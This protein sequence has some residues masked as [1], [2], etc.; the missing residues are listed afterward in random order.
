MQLL[1]MKPFVG[2]FRTTTTILAFLAFSGFSVSLLPPTVVART[3]RSSHL[4]DENRLEVVVT[5]PHLEIPDSPGRLLVAFATGNG[6]PRFTDASFPGQ[7]MF[8]LAVEKLVRDKP[9]VLDDSVTGFP[10]GM[11][12]GKLPP[13]QYKVQAIFTHN[14][15]INL[16]NAPGNLR[17]EVIDVN[18]PLASGETLS[19]PL[20][21][22]IATRPARERAGYELVEIPS[23]LLTA[24]HGRP[25]TLR[26][27][28]ALPLES[29]TVE[30]K[31][32]PTNDTEIPKGLIIHIGGFGQRSTSALGLER[33]PRFVQI[34]LDGA[35]P[36]GDPYYVDSENNGPY[37][38]ALIEEIIPY[39]EKTYVC[40]GSGKYRFT[41]GGSTG[42][43][44]SLALQILYPDSFNGCW[45]SCPDGV[46]FRNFQ[47]INI[48][49]DDNAYFA[50]DG[51]EV[52]A[53]RNRSGAVDYS[54]RHECQL[55]RV[56]GAGRWELGGQQWASWNAVYGPKGVDG[57]VPLWDGETG[58]IDRQTAEAWKRFDLRLILQD[59][60]SR[61]G[62][63]LAGKIHVWVGDKDEYYL[64]LAVERFQAMTTSLTN[65]AF[66]GEITIEP[67]KGHTSGWRSSVIRDAMYERMLGL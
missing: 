11:E 12:L 9:I 53:K 22:V 34:L 4:V 58:K 64:N 67:G 25:M 3:D 7:P 13:G 15:S 51:S 1:K 2:F 52:P 17:S 21:D 49:E 62:P 18:W 19:I 38:Q 28:V 39:V 60:W 5:D 46:D 59:N 27:G 61:L 36:F 42:G 35:G 40:A 16:P 44:V 23:P 66:D 14:P 57:P 63:L 31:S 41:T 30:E 43:W 48:Y 24:F 50:K 6:R 65:P 54:I 26:F 32:T 33:D 29:E 45:S 8:G 55:E 56:L 47:L 20:T 10:V 37:G